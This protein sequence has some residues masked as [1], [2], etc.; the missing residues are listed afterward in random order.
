M[1]SVFLILSALLALVFSSTLRAGTEMTADD[2]K[3]AAAFGYTD[4]EDLKRENEAAS[5]RVNLQAHYDAVAKS[6]Y[7]DRYKAAEMTDKAIGQLLSVAG[8]ALRAKGEVELADEIAYEYEMYYKN[9]VACVVAGCVMEIG[10]HPPMNE[11][12]DSVHEKIHAKMTD[13]WCQYFHFH[14]IEILNHGIPV[15]FAPTKYAFDDYKDHF[16][17]HMDG[18][19]SWVH[20]GVAGVVT[21]WGVN[22]TCSAGTAGLGAVT[23]FCG[24]ISGFAE[25][26]M[27]KRIAPK[28][29]KRIW[30]RANDSQ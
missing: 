30:D 4:V 9:S 23:F 3:A 11:W 10:D 28:V 27:D 8:G 21:Y 6:F 16:A 12:L 14:D 19:F 1:K 18:P 15:V 24:P 7:G 5:A 13:R 2:Y 17:G 25:H 26:V 20:H 29:A 22:I